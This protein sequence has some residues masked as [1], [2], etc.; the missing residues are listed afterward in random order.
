MFVR[1]KQTK[2]VLKVFPD[3]SAKTFGSVV[4][5]AGEKLEPNEFEIVKPSGE[6][7]PKTLALTDESSAASLRVNIGVRLVERGV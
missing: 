7:A 5:A 2:A 6:A 3:Y 1:V 4:T